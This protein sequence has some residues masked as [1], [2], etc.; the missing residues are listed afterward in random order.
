MDSKTNQL[1]EIV[2]IKS[3]IYE[4]IKGNEPIKCREY[5][6]ILKQLIRKNI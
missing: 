1:R 6:K 2:K 3:K 5:I 4:C